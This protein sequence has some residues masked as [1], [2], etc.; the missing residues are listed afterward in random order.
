MVTL[1]GGLR[2][3][4]LDYYHIALKILSLSQGQ[5]W[6]HTIFTKVSTHSPQTISSSGSQKIESTF[7]AGMHGWINF[8]CS[9]PDSTAFTSNI[10]LGH[11]VLIFVEE[12]VAVLNHVTCVQISLESDLHINSNR[13][14]IITCRINDCRELQCVLSV[15]YLVPVGNNGNDV[16]T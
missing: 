4:L 5:C 15:S 3:C 13:R 16:R 11:H 7:A 6:H 12:Q 8:L 10:V 9:C 14:T 2:R 1:N